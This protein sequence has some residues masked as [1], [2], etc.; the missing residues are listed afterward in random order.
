MLPGIFIIW[1]IFSGKLNPETALFGL[2][3]TGLVCYFLIR[4]LGYGIGTEIKIARKL[5]RGLGYIILLVWETMKANLAVSKIVFA[6]KI[7][8]APQLVFFKT[9]LRTDVARVTL[10]N[11]IT[12]T[13]G[14]ITVSL[15]DDQ[16]CVHCLSS[17]LADGIEQSSF[18][19]RLHQLEDE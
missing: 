15:N 14:T 13:P 19:T 7:E 9:S 10:A 16:Y 18:A 11:S 12:L 8:I 17:H 4:H 3:I 2:A 5:F 6:R 1:V